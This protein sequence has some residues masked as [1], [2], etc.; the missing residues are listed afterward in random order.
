MNFIIPILAFI[1]TL[2]ISLCIPLSYGS[3]A[4]MILVESIICIF[5]LGLSVYVFKAI[6][7]LIKNKI[8]RKLI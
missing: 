3:K 7:S 2:L 8:N 5:L 4:G 6:Y 1:I